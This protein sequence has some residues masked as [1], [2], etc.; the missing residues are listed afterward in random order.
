MSRGN[1]KAIGIATSQQSVQGGIEEERGVCLCAASVPN[2]R[3]SSGREKKRERGRKMNFGVQ[4]KNAKICVLRLAFEF[5]GD[6][7]CDL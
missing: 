2:N 7:V 1:W 6:V 4:V 5:N 3:I